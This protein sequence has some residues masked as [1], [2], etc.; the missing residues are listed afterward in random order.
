MITDLSDKGQKT[1]EKRV[2]E[3]SDMLMQCQDYL[4]RYASGDTNLLKCLG[5]MRWTQEALVKTSEE[6]LGQHSPSEDQR[7]KK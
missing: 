7:S 6:L 3:M 5:F 4:R 2:E 1:A